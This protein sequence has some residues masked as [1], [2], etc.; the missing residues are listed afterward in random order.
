MF[1]NIYQQQTYHITEILRLTPTSGILNAH[2]KPGIW[3]QVEYWAVQSSFSPLYTH[4]HTKWTNYS[5][6]IHIQSFYSA[7]IIDSAF[8][9]RMPHMK[10]SQSRLVLIAWLV[11]FCMHSLLCLIIFNFI[12]SIHKVFII[13]CQ[14]LSYYFN[15]N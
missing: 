1:F 11:F 7:H 4:T 2:E 6:L 8:Y 5:L 14:W 13:I 15:S 12:F 10:L 9:F 3:K